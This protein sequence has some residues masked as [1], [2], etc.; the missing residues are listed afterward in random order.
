MWCP[1]C[2]AVAD[3]LSSL[4]RVSSSSDDPSTSIG[5]SGAGA[6]VDKPVAD[7]RYVGSREQWKF[8]ADNVYRR[9]PFE[10]TGVP[11]VLKFRDGKVIARM[12][13]A[14]ILDGTKLEG[15]MGA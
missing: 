14:D 4:F 7:I 3:I 15:F 12:E 1:D 2:E 9:P 5:T 11:T 6:D 8:D 13:E 10:I